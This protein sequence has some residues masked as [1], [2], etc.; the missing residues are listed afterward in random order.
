MKNVIVSRGHMVF[1]M[2]LAFAHACFKGDSRI[3]FNGTDFIVQVGE[4][5]SLADEDEI[6]VGGIFRH[7]Y[8]S[9]LKMPKGDKMSKKYP[10]LTDWQA[11]KMNRDYHYW[12]KLYQGFYNKGINIVHKGEGNGQMIP[13]AETIEVTNEYSGKE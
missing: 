7:K 9:K 13:E 8:F 11:W 3:V 4:N 12:N 2:D 10:D 6:I 5:L 1:L